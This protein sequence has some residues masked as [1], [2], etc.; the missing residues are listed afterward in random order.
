MSRVKLTIDRFR[1]LQKPTVAYDSIRFSIGDQ[2]VLLCKD[3]TEVATIDLG[4]T[5]SKRGN[6]ITINGLRGSLEV[7]LT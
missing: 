6:T 2:F 7:D 4:S 1:T 3:G 5:Y